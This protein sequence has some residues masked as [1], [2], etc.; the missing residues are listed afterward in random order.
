MSMW[1][2]GF[3]SPK[4]QKE[5]SKEKNDSSFSFLATDTENITFPPTAAVRTVI[6]KQ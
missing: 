5:K 4:V 1:Y 6:E 2:G 3:K